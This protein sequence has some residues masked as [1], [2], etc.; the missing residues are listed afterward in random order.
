[1]QFNSSRRT[2]QRA[3]A[4]LGLNLALGI[5]LTAGLSAAAAAHEY[6]AGEIAIGHPYARA[7]APGQPSAGAYFSL[8]NKGAQAD[9]LVSVNA[10]IA[11]STQIHMMSMEGDVMKMREVGPLAIKPAEK[12]VMKPGGG[13]HIMLIGLSQ[14]LKAGD[15]FPMTLTFEKAGKVEVSVYVEDVKAGDKPMEHMH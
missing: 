1:M 14:P 7:T 3:I 10:A 8:E 4:V 15:K 5:G 9:T 11:K 6:K 13:Y 2:M 12:I